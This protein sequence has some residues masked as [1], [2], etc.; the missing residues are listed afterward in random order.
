[1]DVSNLALIM[2]SA[3]YLQMASLID[4]CVDYVVKNI[5]LVIEKGE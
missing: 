4:F 2:M 3:D 1:M 5:N